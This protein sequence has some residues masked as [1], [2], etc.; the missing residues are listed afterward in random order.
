MNLVFGK[1][2]SSRGLVRDAVRGLSGGGGPVVGSSAFVV[3]ALLA[4]LVGM[5]GLS[6]LWSCCCG[7]GFQLD[8]AGDGL[9]AEF[10]LFTR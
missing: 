1:D 6:V 7:C 9:R 10:G 2:V 5:R 3:A 8:R 4:V